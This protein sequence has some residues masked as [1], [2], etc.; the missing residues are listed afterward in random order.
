M[1]V[2]AE[3]FRKLVKVT[4]V[5]LELDWMFIR[6]FDIVCNEWLMML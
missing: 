6:L 5:S 3:E 4:L 1:S 2:S